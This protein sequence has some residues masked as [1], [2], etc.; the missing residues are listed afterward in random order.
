M[1]RLGCALREVAALRLEDIDW[2]AGLVTVHGKGGRVDRLPLPVDVGEA[3]AGYLRH[4]L[5]PDRGPP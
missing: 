4:G 1:L 2:R 5:L 3:I